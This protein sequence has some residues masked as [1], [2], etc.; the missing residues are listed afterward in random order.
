MTFLW[1]WISLSYLC[2]PSITL[3]ISWAWLLSGGWN[4]FGNSISSL[5]EPQRLGWFSKSHCGGFA[6]G[7]ITYAS[8]FIPQF[9]ED[10][11]FPGLLRKKCHIWLLL[12]KKGL[13]DSE[14]YSWSRLLIN[15]DRV[16]STKGNQK[17]EQT[18]QVAQFPVTHIKKSYHDFDFFLG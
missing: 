3:P 7:C 17:L 12:G 4:N 16:K 5:N 6:L 8:C 14:W 9:L 15:L 13:R 18:F 1:M 10:S 11:S 2:S